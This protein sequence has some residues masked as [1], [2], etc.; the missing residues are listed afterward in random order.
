MIIVAMTA[1]GLRTNLRSLV[2]NGIRPILLGLVCWFSVSAV[3]LIVQYM[4]GLI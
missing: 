3:S 4:T 2:R 1:I